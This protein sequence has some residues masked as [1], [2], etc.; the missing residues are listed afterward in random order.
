MKRF[1]CILVK[2]SFWRKF[3]F[4][5]PQSLHRIKNLSFL[6]HLIKSTVPWRHIRIS[7]LQDYFQ[8]SPEQ[9]DDCLAS[10]EFKLQEHPQL[11]QVGNVKGPKGPKGDS[12]APVW[13]RPYERRHKVALS[14]PHSLILLLAFSIL[15]PVLL[16]LAVI[17]APSAGALHFVH[18]WVLGHPVCHSG[19]LGTIPPTLFAPLFFSPRFLVTQLVIPAL[20]VPYPLP[21]FHHSSSHLGS[22]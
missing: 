3:G 7:D 8:L 11:M 10:H 12:P 22:W 20:L 6:P 19:P 5:C 14:S 17:P 2:Q 15:P 9:W 18:N 16:A 21:Y 1:F 4:Q 13:K